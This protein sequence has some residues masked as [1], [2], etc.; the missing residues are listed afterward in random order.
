MSQYLKAL[1]DLQDILFF[2]LNSVPQ[3]WEER[4]WIQV[5]LWGCDKEFVTHFLESY[6]SCMQ[7]VQESPGGKSAKYKNLDQRKIS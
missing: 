2:L 4:D 5:I 3:K 7:Y 6:V 1:P